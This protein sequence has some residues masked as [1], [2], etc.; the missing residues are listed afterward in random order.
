MNV[1]ITSTIEQFSTNLTIIAWNLGGDLV[2]DFGGD[3]RGN[4][5]GCVDSQWL[6]RSLQLLNIFSHT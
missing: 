3:L 2:G 5:G 1:E 4:L 6:L